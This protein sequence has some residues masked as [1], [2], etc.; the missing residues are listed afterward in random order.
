MEP[1]DAPPHALSKV[2]TRPGRS[3]G[4][5][6]PICGRFITS[7]DIQRHAD[8]CARKMF[9]SG[10]VHRAAPKKGARLAS[11]SFRGHRRAPARSRAPALASALVFLSSFADRAREAVR[12]D[13]LF[14]AARA[15]PGAKARE[16]ADGARVQDD[17]PA[18]DGLDST[19]GGP[20]PATNGGSPSVGLHR[21][22]AQQGAASSS[23]QPPPAK[24]LRGLT[25]G[26]A[27]APTLAPHPRKRIVPLAD[28][29]EIEGYVIKSMKP[30]R[31]MPLW[32][33]LRPGEF[34]GPPKGGRHQLQG[35]GAGV[36]SSI[37]PS[38]SPTPT[39]RFDQDGMPIPRVAELAAASVRRSMPADGELL[40][41]GSLG[42]QA[43]RQR[44]P[45]GTAG[46]LLRPKVRSLGR[47]PFPRAPRPRRSRAFAS[48]RAMH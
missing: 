1:P 32:P 38:L 16:R 21:S 12:R 47:D 35:V 7:M 15:G 17:A 14:S 45:V 48:L 30:N 20:S 28:Y 27:Q 39:V 3:M 2:R 4:A 11:A 25:G 37:W 33:V 36:G 22:R 43:S 8:R 29:T 24:K 46:A 18:G 31:S 26:K 5:D 44:A 42:A 9:G 23:P 13:P 40:A 34:V 41:R 6:C 19:E 10:V